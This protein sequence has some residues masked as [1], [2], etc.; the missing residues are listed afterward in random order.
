VSVTAILPDQYVTSGVLC[1]SSN[2]RY[3]YIACYVR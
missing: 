2:L 3:M 1:N